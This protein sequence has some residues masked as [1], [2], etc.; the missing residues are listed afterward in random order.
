MTMQSLSWS[1]RWCQGRS[2]SIAPSGVCCTCDGLLA[3]TLHAGADRQLPSQVSRLLEFK[4]LQ[5]LSRQR[6]L[7]PFHTHPPHPLPNRFYQPE[8]SLMRQTVKIKALPGSETTFAGGGLRG[9]AVACSHPDI[10]VGAGSSGLVGG[11]NERDEVSACWLGVGR[12]VCGRTYEILHAYWPE[13]GSSRLNTG[14]GHFLTT[15]FC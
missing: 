5:Q 6:N 1:C 4:L 11:S 8:H 9:L 10:I 14:Y 15:N 2:S 12:N 3:C 13:R 7:R